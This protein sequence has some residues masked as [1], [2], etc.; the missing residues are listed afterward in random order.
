MITVEN[1]RNILQSTCPKG[2][3]ECEKCLNKISDFDNSK[4]SEVIAKSKTEAT[5]FNKLFFDY[6]KSL[7]LP[8]E[9]KIKYIVAINV[10]IKKLQVLDINCLEFEPTVMTTEQRRAYVLKATQDEGKSAEDLAMTLM[11]SKRTIRR[12]MK[13]IREKYNVGVESQS[14]QKNNVDGER[15][16]RKYVMPNTLHEI[17]MVMTMEELFIIFKALNDL[18]N[19]I[20]WPWVNRIG[21]L[22]AR[23]WKQLEN[24]ENNNYAQNRI[25]QLMQRIDGRFEALYTKMEEINEEYDTSKFDYEEYI[26]Q[27]KFGEVWGYISK[28]ENV[29]VAGEYKDE[30]GNIINIYGCAVS[31][32]KRNDK[33]AIIDR[34]VIE[35]DGTERHIVKNVEKSK[36]VFLLPL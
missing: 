13:E 14:P 3:L 17:D 32:D 15:Q 12:Y 6:I 11:V 21:Y 33:V 7:P 2:N 18:C 25:K 29:K 23:I 28:R 34:T 10:W 30:D 19:Q 8:P 35:D 4:I 1:V 22:G 24:Y 27:M 26:L 36:F 20:E 9:K 5:V 31:V 16:N